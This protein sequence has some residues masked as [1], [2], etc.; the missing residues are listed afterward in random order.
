MRY[1]LVSAAVISLAVS[2]GFAQ[3]VVERREVKVE[4]SVVMGK[5]VKGAPY[6]ADEITETTQ[7]LADGTHIN[8]QSQTTVY[9][10][11]EGRVRRETP[12][13]I[14][15]WDPV[16][17]VSYSLDPATKTARKS[18]L[19]RF[20]VAYFASGTG[21]ASTH[22]VVAPD[23]AQY[24]LAVGGKDG[25]VTISNESVDPKMAA[26]ALEKLT[27]AMRG[28]AA[29]AVV[30]DGSA[31]NQAAASAVKEQLVLA[32]EKLAKGELGGEAKTESLGKQTFWGVE[33]DG[34]RST[35]VIETGAIGNDRPISIVAE[36][37]YSS[38]LQ[39]L[40]MTRNSD[41]RTGDEVFRLA[42][43][44]RGEPGADLFMVPPGYT[45]K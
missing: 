36:R 43:I 13:E 30:I 9:R 39:T 11:G 34:T 5:P 3:T 10:D 32:K 23:S 24:N 1:F 29:N 44:R 21:S 26:A 25:A 35:S 20:N 8:R 37:W 40:M 41:P 14:T 33:A 2:E 31:A 19:G 38:D 15:I 6:T 45:V 27:E 12:K 4:K 17:N 42:N 7:M 16:A 22:F 28:A 18:P